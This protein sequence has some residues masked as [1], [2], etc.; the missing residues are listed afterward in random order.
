[1]SPGRSSTCAAKPTELLKPSSLLSLLHV[2]YRPSAMTYPGY[3]AHSLQ[4]VL[5][6]PAPHLPSAY[7]A[8]K[9]AF[10]DMYSHTVGVLPLQMY[11]PSKASEQHAVLRVLLPPNYPSAAGPVMELE[12]GPT[13][14]QNIADAVKHME[15]MYC[16]G[17]Q[18]TCL[19]KTG[20]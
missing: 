2:L 14:Q 9:P 6:H 5:P 11:F 20:A 8:V 4:Q 3:Y 13:P 17:K 15:A 19:H 1:M 16:P 10:A 18:R 7:T 12:A